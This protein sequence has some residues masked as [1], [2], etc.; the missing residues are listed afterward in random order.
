MAKHQITNFALPVEIM[1]IILSQCSHTDLR[2]L[3]NILYFKPYHQVIEKYKEFI[4]FKTRNYWNSLHFSTI[5]DELRYLIDNNKLGLMLDSG[6]WSPLMIKQIE[7]TLDFNQYYYD[8]IEHQM[9]MIRYIESYP[10]LAFTMSQLIDKYNMMEVG[11]L[12]Y[13]LSQKR[14]ELLNSMNGA[15]KTYFEHR[16]SEKREE[17]DSL[18]YKKLNHNQLN[19]IIQSITVDTTMIEY[20][21]FESTLNRT[22]C[23]NKKTDVSHD[24]HTDISHLALPYHLPF[25]HHHFIHHF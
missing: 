25:K 5:R 13:Q 4:D 21:H 23:G 20:I 1:D 19:R 12:P 6:R 8:I 7:L 14:Q 15:I 22:L 18:Y 16:S 10:T 9:A 17:H 3:K 2:H 24:N 11:I